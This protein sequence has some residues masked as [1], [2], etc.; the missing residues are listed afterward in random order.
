MC[1]KSKGRPCFFR[2]RHEIGQVPVSAVFVEIGLADPVADGPVRALERALGA[3]VPSFATLGW[4]SSGGYGGC[5]RGIV[6]SPS[7]KPKGSVSTKAG[8]LQSENPQPQPRTHPCSALLSGNRGSMGPEP[9][10]HANRGSSARPP[11]KRRSGRCTS[12]L[13]DPPF[14]V[15]GNP[16]IEGILRSFAKAVHPRSRGD[17]NRTYTRSGP[18]FGVRSGDAVSSPAVVSRH[19]F[20]LAPRVRAPAPDR[21]HELADADGATAPGAMS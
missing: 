20:G 4:R 5:A 9:A 13:P 12:D 15:L 17:T 16:G 8:Q 6:D 10:S 11:P 3:P 19:G 21:R 2:A 14:P 7:R 1:S 18:A